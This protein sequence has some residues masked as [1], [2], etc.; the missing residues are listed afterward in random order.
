M[1]TGRPR[2]KPVRQSASPVRSLP[3]VISVT[4]DASPPSPVSPQGAPLDQPQRALLSSNVADVSNVESPLPRPLPKQFVVVPTSQIPRE[5]FSL[6]DPEQP[7][8]AD[9]LGQLLGVLRLTGLRATQHFVSFLESR[10]GRD[11]S[12]EKVREVEVA[13]CALLLVIA[14]LI[15]VYVCSPHTITH[16][17]HWDFLNPP[18]G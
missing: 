8:L 15:L 7:G 9:S 2:E 4:P 16:H 10:M 5:F 13:I 1:T 14:A 18:Q 12:E 6:G 17:H 11:S 3:P